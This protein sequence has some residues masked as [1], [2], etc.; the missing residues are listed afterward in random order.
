MIIVSLKGGL[1]NQMFQYAAGRRLADATEQELKLDL[2]FFE[3]S[4]NLRHVTH[5]GY[6]LSALKIIEKLAN[7]N[8]INQLK[9]VK[10][11]ILAQVFP[12]WSGNPYAKERH[13][14][15]DPMILTLKGQRYMEGNWM[16]EK[17]FGDIS[18]IIR[19]EFAFKSEV[20]ERGKNLQTL[21]LDSDSVCI[22]VRR[23]D[24]VSNPHVARLHQTTSLSYFE[25][26][27]ALL[28]RKVSRPF[29]FVFSDD[30]AWCKEHFNDLGEVH[31]VEGDLAGHGAQNSDYMQ[32]MMCCKH[33]IISNSTFGW[34]GAW[35]GNFDKKVVISPQKWFNDER[36]STNDICPSTWMKI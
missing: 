34:W 19:E 21:I 18:A 23:G 26:G 1:G 22:Q 3:K 4:K 2:S 27:V 35:L 29:F 24:Y 8:E 9:S 6:E 30:T 32:L 17:Y 28:K 7:E 15:F 12:K 25:Q 13:F 20:I 14:H 16:S 11:R 33:F 31:F 5:R 36:I 10:N